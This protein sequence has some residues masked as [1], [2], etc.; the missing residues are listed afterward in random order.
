MS[1]K[2]CACFFLTIQLSACYLEGSSCSGPFCLTVATDFNNDSCFADCD[3]QFRCPDADNTRFLVTDAI[4]AARQSPALTRCQ[5]SP[6]RSLVP[7][8]WNETLFVAADRQARDMASN[9]FVDGLGSD[10]VSI[11]VRVNALDGSPD[12]GSFSNVRQL[13]AGGFPDSRIL[14]NEWL[15][16]NT[17]C[18][19]LLSAA[20]TQFAMACRYDSNSDFGTYWSL[21]LAAE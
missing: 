17:D 1:Y 4:N 12:N 14:I 3:R 11:D 19:A 5:A 18:E 13:V 8:A 6:D 7:V 20:V 15:S 10:G 21:V 16:N 2:A 9:N